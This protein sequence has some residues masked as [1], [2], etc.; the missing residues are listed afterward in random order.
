MKTRL[1]AVLMI[2]LMVL[3][4][5][6][7]VAVTA[8]STSSASSI[9]QSLKQSNKVT[10]IIKGK[11]GGTSTNNPYLVPIGQNRIWDEKLFNVHDTYIS[12]QQNTVDVTCSSVKST[13]STDVNVKG[14]AIMR[15]EGDCFAWLGVKFQIAGITSQPVWNLIKNK[16]VRISTTVDYTFTGKANP[17]TPKGTTDAGVSNSL[18]LIGGADP[19]NPNIAQTIDSLKQPGTISMT[20]VTTSITT[21]LDKLGTGIPGQCE[22]AVPLATGAYGD[23]GG[24]AEATGN[25]VVTNIQL[26]W[27]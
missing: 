6:S 1:I 26:T 12:V 2:T 23:E 19:K 9:S 11:S 13:L 5:F 21:T 16:Q 14:S 4:V 18:S 10:V 8:K 24:V 17:E 7:A 25:A 22:I 27:V 3:T 20:Q 15:S